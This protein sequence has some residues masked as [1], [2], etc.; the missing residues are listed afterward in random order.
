MTVAVLDD[1]QVSLLRWIDQGL[2]LWPQLS[3]WPLEARGLSRVVSRT[4]RRYIV[5]RL[6][7]CP[8]ALPDHYCDVL[9][10]SRGSTYGDAVRKIWFEHL[11]EEQAPSGSQE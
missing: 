10:L 5:R 1:A 8:E 2:H 6:W 7:E 11:G 3:R 4:W 9:R